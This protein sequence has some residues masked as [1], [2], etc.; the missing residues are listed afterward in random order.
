[1]IKNE[2]Q[3]RVYTPGEV[4]NLFKIRRPT[5]GE[6]CRKGVLEKID[7]PGQRRVYVKAESVDKLIEGPK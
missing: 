1:V 3:R 4:M 2:V 5:F 6:W 7:I